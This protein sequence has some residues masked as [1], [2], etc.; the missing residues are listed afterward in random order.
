VLVVFQEPPK[1][2]KPMHW[3]PKAATL[4]QKQASQMAKHSRGG[5]HN[6]RYLQAKTIVHYDDFA[7]SD[8]FTVN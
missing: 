3:L 6:L 4:Q 8:Q 7:V 2:P 1:N 5:I